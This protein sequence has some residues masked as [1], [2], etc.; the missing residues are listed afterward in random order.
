MDIQDL[1]SIGEIVAAIATLLTLV[2]LAIQIRQ[3]TTA[4]G[5]ATV[6]SAVQ[7]SVGF[8]QSLYE[9]P[10][11]SELFRRGLTAPEALDE[12]ERFRFDIMLIT[13]SRMAQNSQHQFDRGLIDEETWRGLADGYLS[14]MKQPGGRQGWARIE[15]RFDR[16]FREFVD[17]ELG[18]QS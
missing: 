4:L 3:N 8:G 1:G 5:A 13:L 16:A 15:A 17:R 9:N 6:Q 7:F 12:G 11:A 10:E 14:F 2:Y 18:G